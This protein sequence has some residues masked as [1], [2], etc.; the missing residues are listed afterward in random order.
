[1]K[2]ILFPILILIAVMIAGCYEDCEDGDYKP[3]DC[4]ESKP[5]EGQV[6]LKITL[7]NMNT[8]VPVEFFIGDVE[9]NVFYFADTISTQTVSYTLP[10]NYYSV[11]AKYRAIINGNSVTVYSIDGGSLDAF[12]T[13]YCDGVCYSNGSLDLDAKLEL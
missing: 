4:N 12:E 10:N 1:M 3:A 2:V 11:R 13:D 7:N 6:T 9:E 8:Q 5:V